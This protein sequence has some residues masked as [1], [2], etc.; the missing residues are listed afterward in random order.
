MLEDYLAGVRC[1]LSHLGL[2][3]CD[4]VAGGIC[5]H[6]EGANPALARGG[7]GYREDNREVC[8]FARG[9]ELLGAIED[10]AIAL[11]LGAR[12]EPRGIAASL[13]LGKAER[14]QFFAAGEGG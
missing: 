6:H 8:I 1:A 12:F 7:V 5:W 4:A 14:G 10:I 2:D 3:T 9:D 13:R 11:P